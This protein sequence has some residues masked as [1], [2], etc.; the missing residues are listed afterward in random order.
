M[1]IKHHYALRKGYVRLLRLM[2]SQWWPSAVAVLTNT[3]TGIIND[4]VM[5]TL[6]FINY[7]VMFM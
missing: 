4:Y 7:K 5:V 3:P 2:V 6:T 1:L